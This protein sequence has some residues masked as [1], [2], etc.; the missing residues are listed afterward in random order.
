MNKWSFLISSAPGN[1]T[2]LQKCIN[3]IWDEYLGDCEIIV[4][5]NVAVNGPNKII[6]FDES[7]KPGWITRK[8][9]LMVEAASNENLVLL[10]DYFLLN[11]GF[12]EGF[13]AF[14]GSWHVCMCKIFNSDGVSRYR[15]WVV[16]DDPRHGPPWFQFEHP[17]TPPQG[18]FT[19]GKAFIPPY[20]YNSD[21]SNTKHMY[22]SGG[23]WIAKRSF[24]KKYPLDERIAHNGAEDI[25]WCRRWRENLLV[26]YK[27]NTGSSMR[28]AK[29]KDVILKEVNII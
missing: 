29:S 23:A 22:I 10:H 14:G 7:V 11:E 27:M 19:H 3:S 13:E 15:D 9:N 28:L 20:E 25:E 12:R 16:W 8:K 21:G 4:C 18:L 5:G 24:M 26:E 17:W 6:P 1:E 2:N